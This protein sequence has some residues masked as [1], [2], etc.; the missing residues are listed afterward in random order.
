MMLEKCKYVRCIFVDFSKAFDV[1][2]HRI[3]I[4]K[5]VALNVPNFIVGWIKSFLTGRSHATKFN[6]K[7][8]P[9]ATIN[10]SIVQ[11]SGLGPVLFIMFVYDLITLDD[12][13]YLMKYA[14]DMTLLNP[15]NAKTSAE[16]EMKNILGWATRNKMIVNMLKT[17]EM[18][19]HRPN[20][21]QFICTSNLDEVERV[22]SFKLLGV[23]FKPDLSFSDHVSRL[24]T[25]CNQRLYLLTQLNSKSKESV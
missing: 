25:I 6:G 4:D 1:V 23:Y 3:L 17:K 8:S 13:N 15:E 5:L 14:D 11:G 20:P 24:L 19:F 12:V 9:T 18:V 22:N 16:T 2:D 21:R 7:L 10:Q